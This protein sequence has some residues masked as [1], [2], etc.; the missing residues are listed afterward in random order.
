MKTLGFSSL[1]LLTRGLLT[2]ALLAGGWVSSADG[3]QF[4]L[5]PSA[6]T[7]SDPV[8][9]DA[10]AGTGF[11]GERK[12]WS[13]AH[14]VRFVVRAARTVDLKRAAS[15]GDMKWARFAPTDDGGAMIAFESTFTPIQLAAA[16]FDT[17]LED[18]GLASARNA[19]ARGAPEV[20][21]RERYRRCAKAWLSGRDVARATSPIGMPLEIV[22]GAAPGSGP[23]L[24]ISVLREGRPLA[25]ALVR[26]WRAP[27]DS[28][29]RPA[30]AASRDS[31]RIAWQARTDARGCVSV[32]ARESGEWL[33][34]V[35]D[36]VPCPDKGEA[37]WE[38]TWASL[39]FARGPR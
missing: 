9:V 29:G 37:D 30:D 23:L 5:S 12:P 16:P 31:L 4:W 13:P 26:A 28:S 7:G 24:A 18:E 36:M 8:S 21:G 19:R 17:Y 27:L 39:T 6:Y 2:C 10:L 35:V 11:R 3:H 22:P 1:C 25:G 14:A 20:P 15:P 34:S 32:P 33:V 38:S